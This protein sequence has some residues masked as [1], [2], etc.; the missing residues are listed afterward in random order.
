MT[1]AAVSDIIRKDN[2]SQRKAVLR[3]DTGHSLLHT[4]LGAYFISLLI[5]DIPDSEGFYGTRGN[6][7]ADH[8]DRLPDRKVPSVWKTRMRRDNDVHA[9]AP[10]VV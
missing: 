2:Q 5:V 6:D 10:V 3:E 1:L 9:P 4:D 8:D 7:I